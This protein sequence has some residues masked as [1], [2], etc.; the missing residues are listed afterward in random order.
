MR[1]S[2]VGSRLQRAGFLERMG[3]F[4]NVPSVDVFGSCVFG[5]CLLQPQQHTPYPVGAPAVPS[6]TSRSQQ[7]RIWTRCDHLRGQIRP[8]NVKGPEI[9]VVIRAP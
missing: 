5:S 9:L 7:F 4:R 3:R 2:Q 8:R 1:L 6:P